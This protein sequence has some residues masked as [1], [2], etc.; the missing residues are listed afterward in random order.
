[1][2]EGKFLAF[3][4]GVETGRAMLGTLTGGK[5]TLEERHRWPTP[6]GR[7]GG[8]AQWDLLGIWEQ[9]KTG[10][11]A[12]KGMPL[13]GIG[14][15]AWALDYGLLGPGGTLLGNPI[16]YGDP[17]THGVMN[18]AF[19]TVPRTEIFAA[20]G[21]QLMAI[22]TL[23]QLI[24]ARQQQPATLA[25]AERLLFVADLVLYLLGAPPGTDPTL[26][27]ASQLYDPAKGDWAVDLVAKFTLP[28]AVLPNVV[29]CGTRVGTLSAEIAGEC[30]LPPAP[31]IVAAGHDAAAAV[32]AVPA[33]GDDWGFIVSGTWSSVGVERHGPLINT[34]TL[35]NGFTNES[36]VAGTTR[37][38]KHVTGLWLVQECRRQFIRD[39]YDHSYSELVTMASRAKPFALVVDPNDPPFAVPG[40]MPQ[41]LASFAKLTGQ[42]EPSTRGAA[43]RACFDSLALQYRQALE[44][45]EE[46]TGRKI[47][48]IHLVGLGA[49]NEMLNQL[50]ADVCGR[51]VLAGPVEAT[52]IGNLLLQATAAGAI[53]GL[54]DARGVVR[55]S[56][57]VKRYAPKPTPAIEAAYARFKAFTSAG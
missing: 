7:L 56:F 23:Y 4:L 49:Q 20:T 33:E 41:K 19:D 48:V 22:N 32:A 21:V 8:A 31:L 51:P 36:G 1:M 11:R 45:L 18:R 52:A 16:T 43:V 50:T 17:R 57:A 6:S 29:P 40:G 37:L 27:S 26:A 25:T 5:L 12:L 35:A 24:A 55:Q 46:V 15:S 42:A 10:L 39:G 3:D 53:D 38:L 13:G 54:A 9:V 44:R 2:A 47:N 14:V 28:A 30:D 34:Q